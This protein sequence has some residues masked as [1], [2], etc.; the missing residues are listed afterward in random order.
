[1]N[2]E[3]FPHT[4]GSSPPVEKTV[5]ATHETDEEKKRKWFEDAQ[6]NGWTFVYFPDRGAGRQLPRKMLIVAE[7]VEAGTILRMLIDETQIE[8]M[9]PTQP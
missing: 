5:I 3:K 7:G 9:S 6:E 2:S 8:E 4:T 1:M